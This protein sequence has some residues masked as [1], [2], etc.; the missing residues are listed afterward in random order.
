MPAPPPV[1]RRTRPPRTLRGGAR[2]TRPRGSSARL[3]PPQP[4]VEAP[5][6]LL[7]VTQRERGRFDR[8]R[9][10]CG[11]NPPAQP[12]VRAVILLHRSRVISGTGGDTGWRPHELTDVGAREA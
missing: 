9:P 5:F 6:V 10:L 12:L 4:C 8:H 2:S 3:R 11:H 1:R 7:T